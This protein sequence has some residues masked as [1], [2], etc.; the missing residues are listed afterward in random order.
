[1]VNTP[2]TQHNAEIAL[3][4]QYWDAKPLLQ[5]IYADFYRLI[6]AAFNTTTGEGIL[7]IGSGIGAIKTV[8]PKC[9]TSDLFENPWLDRVESAYSISLP[10]QSLNGILL[11]DVWHH[12]RFPSL[13]LREFARVL[14]PGGKVVL[15]EPAMGLL[16]RLI[17]GL[18]HHEPLGFGDKITWDHPEGQLPALDYYA[19]Q[20][21]CWRMFKTQADPLP[22]HLPFTVSGVRTMSAISYAASGG[23]SKP[24]LYPTFC[25]RPITKLE[26]V[27]DLVP[28]VF[29]TRMIVVLT[30]SSETLRQH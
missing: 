17:Y 18:F 28:S 5:I 10:N 30:K 21:N 16:G 8:L 25:Y 20:G 14:K 1:M 7:E 26:K 4:R 13:A 12:L 15:F 11:F 2:V 22:K 9:T 6:A 24:Q 3:N 27:L 29:A 23:F 19:A